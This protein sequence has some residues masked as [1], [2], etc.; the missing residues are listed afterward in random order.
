MNKEKMNVAQFFALMMLFNFGTNLVVGVGIDAKK[1]AWIAILIG[2]LGGIL[3]FILYHYLYSLYPTLSPIGYS[4]KIL[5][6]YIGGLIGFFYISFFIY[7]AARDLRDAGELIGASILDTTPY[8]TIG[9]L[10]IFSIAYILY[11]GIEVLARTAEIFFGGIFMLGIL[12]NL[13]IYISGL[14]DVREILPIIEFGWKPILKSIP[15]TVMFPFGEMVAFTFL[16][17]YINRRKKILNVGIIGIVLSGVIISYTTFINLSVLGIEI[18]TRTEFPLLITVKGIE[19]R[20][21]IEHVDVIAVLTLIFGAFFK[22]AIF[23]FAAI[24]AISDLFKVEKKENVILSTGLVI[25][26]T[27]MIIAANFPEHLNEGEFA[28]KSIF[29]LFSFVFPFLYCLVAFIREKVNKHRL[30][31]TK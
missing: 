12:G 23:Y 31:I 24:V 11:K 5:G 8:A 13:L 19:I 1:D 10:M 27:S 28:L 30:G 22:I 29:P 6:K 26:F 16:L 4:K 14:V 21:I 17:P 15:V 2:I 9:A 7:A 20:G 3:L 25:L 18:L